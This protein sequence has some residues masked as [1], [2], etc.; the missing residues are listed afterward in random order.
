MWMVVINFR[1]GKIEVV[2]G[3]GGG[4][5]RFGDRGHLRGLRM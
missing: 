4:Y 1:E 5:S 2:G 3:G